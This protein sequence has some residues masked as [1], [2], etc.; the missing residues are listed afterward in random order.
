MFVTVWIFSTIC[1]KSLSITIAGP[2]FV[3]TMLMTQTV[4]VC[5]DSFV[6]MKMKNAC[7]SNFVVLPFL[8]QKNGF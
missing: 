6:R 4:S 8:S 5:I 1:R 3:S 7:M 2:R